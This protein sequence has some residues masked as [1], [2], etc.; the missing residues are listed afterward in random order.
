MRIML[1]VLT[2]VKGITVH[3]VKVRE[4]SEIISQKIMCVLRLPDTYAV[5]VKPERKADRT[6]VGKRRKYMF[7]G[8]VKYSCGS[9]AE[10]ELRKG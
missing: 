4:E 10:C 7:G 5:G 8:V 6:E 3:Y 2:K 9:K 1:K